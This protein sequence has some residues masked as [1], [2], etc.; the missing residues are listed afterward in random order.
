M[1]VFINK[2]K[3]SLSVVIVMFMLVFTSC[4]SELD[5]EPITELT[6]AQVFSDPDSYE[7]FM[8]RVYAGLAVSGQQGPAGQPD[9]Q[10]IDEGFSNYIRQFWKHQELTTDEAII[11]WKDG[12]IHDLHNQVWTP[13]NEF[14][15]AMY[16]R[17]YFQ[18][19]ITNQ[20]LRETTAEKLD[21]RGVDGTLRE[22]VEVFRAEA[23]F[24]RALSY[25][26]ALDFYGNVPFVTEDDIVGN[27]FPAQISRPDLF[28]FIESELLAIEGTLKGARQNDLGR[29]DK[30]AAWMLLAKLYLNAEVYTGSGRYTEA[31]TYINKVINEGGYSLVD[32]YQKLFLADNDRNGAQN[33][34]I[35]TVRFDGVSTLG[36]G[37]T[38][39]LT[40]AAVGGEMDAAEFG[41]NGGWAG[42]RTTKNL[43]KKFDEKPDLASLNTALGAATDWGL[44][45]SA[46]TNGW[47]GPDMEMR[48]TGTN[49]Y[50]L[51]ADLKAGEI[52]FRFDEDWGNNYGGN[53]GNLESGGANIAVSSAGIYYVTMDLN[54]NKYTLTFSGDSR[55]ML[56]S[57]GQT[58]EIEDP[59]NFTD[60]YAIAKYRNVDVNGNR[61]NDNAGEFVDIDFP[62]FR[63]A[64]AYLMYAEAFL[65]GGGGDANSAVS[66]INMLR[67]RAYGSGSGNISSGNLTLNFILD[68]RSRELFWE[69]HRRTDLIR[70]GQFS[71]QGIWPWKGG[72]MEGKT[73]E[74]F[75]DIYP[76]P[77]SDLIANPTLVQNPGY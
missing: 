19:G 1:K 38:T 39:F 37:G 62:M 32:D 66:Y 26:H 50:A 29:A 31:M 28:S 58:L 71:T 49:T 42:I 40:H 18:V 51:Y 20:F 47:D 61:G 64:D 70:F 16:D 77:S 75:R 72:V 24:M 27:F 7:Q 44:V 23:R 2:T 36:Y 25:W 13:S 60:G 52:K 74:A 68:E 67:E 8:A 12:T 73:T 69:G 65:K 76:I 35:F 34:T 6:E 57:E 56:F 3:I 63:L 11:A 41:I 10:G 43:V 15:R 48:S 30:G 45:G 33:E 46:T 22:E 9:I 21:G 4:E 17:I 59:F 55:N 5:K 53:N 54:T 14:V